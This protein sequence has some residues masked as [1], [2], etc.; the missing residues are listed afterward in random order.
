MEGGGGGGGTEGFTSGEGPAGI[1]R[2]VWILRSVEHRDPKRSSFLA[3][4]AERLASVSFAAAIASLAAAAASLAAAAET[5]LDST[6][7]L[8]N[9]SSSVKR[10]V[11]RDGVINWGEER[12]KSTEDVWGWWLLEIK[13]VE[14]LEDCNGEGIAICWRIGVS[15]VWAIDES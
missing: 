5:A 10:F 9:A 2:N 7:A 8:V 14:V 11:G 12:T 4:L 13:L 1:L 15:E 3:S 6:S